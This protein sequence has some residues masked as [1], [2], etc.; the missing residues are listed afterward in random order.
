MLFWTT[1]GVINEDY[2]GLIGVILINHGSD[3]FQVN[4]GDRI[5]QLI[6]HKILHPKVVEVNVCTYICI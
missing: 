2:T 3:D 5:A 6:V 1:A 4:V